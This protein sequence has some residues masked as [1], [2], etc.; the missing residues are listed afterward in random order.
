MGLS[1]ESHAAAFSYSIL[2]SS[3]KQKL[4][5][6]IAKLFQSTGE[7]KYATPHAKFVQIP[8]KGSK[9]CTYSALDTYTRLGIT[10]TQ[11]RH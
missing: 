11:G 1:A 4:C 7:R 6:E 2:A 5:L 10:I 8:D 3:G 9:V